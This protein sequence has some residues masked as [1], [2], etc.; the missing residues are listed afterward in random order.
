VTDA[1]G[2]G[3]DA[4][5]G[6]T[7]LVSG[8][9]RGIGLAIARALGARGANVALLAKT[10]QERPGLEGTVFTAA[11]EVAA[12]G[13]DVLPIATDIRDEEQ[14]ARAV[15]R[16]VERFGGIDICVNNA[17]AIV[18]E[19]SDRLSMK[20]Y[21]LMHAVNARGTFLVSRACV[22][23][24]REARNPHVLTL[25]PPLTLDPKWFAPHLGYTMAKMGMSLCTLGMAVEFGE[26]GIAFNSLW[27]RT[28]IATD[29]VRNVIGGDRAL[30]RSR[31]PRIV[32]DAALVILGRDSRRTTGRFYLDEEVLREAG[33]DD[34][35]HYAVGESGGL[36]IDLFVDSA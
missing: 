30:A 3:R 24:L 29:A 8:A 13:G 23:H 18:L 21:D 19:R 22:P 6:A 33:V 28:L 17:S 16:T 5:A 14:V 20:R 7:A 26:D 25:S 36:Q 9:S 35:S 11:A 31:S 2:N 32:A 1:R 4:F 12:A 10:V 27:P 34:F 15:D